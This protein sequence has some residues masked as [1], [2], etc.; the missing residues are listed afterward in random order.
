MARPP[1][2]DRGAHEAEEGKGGET[3]DVAAGAQLDIKTAQ[4]RGSGLKRHGSLLYVRFAFPPPV[5]KRVGGTERGWRTGYRKPASPKAPPPGPPIDRRLAQAL[6]TKKAAR[7]LC[8]CSFRVAKP[9]RAMGRG[10]DILERVGNSVKSFSERPGVR[11]WR[12]DSVSWPRD[13]RKSGRRASKGRTVPKNIKLSPLGA[14]R[15]KAF[16]DYFRCPSCNSPLTIKPKDRDCNELV[17]SGCEKCR[18][19][20][21][22]RRR[23]C[24]RC[25]A[26]MVIRSSRP[27]GESNKELPDRRFP[28]M[29]VSTRIDD[30]YCLCQ[31]CGHTAPRLREKSVVQQHPL[32]RLEAEIGRR[33]AELDTL[34]ERYREQSVVF[35]KKRKRT[36]GAGL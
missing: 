15:L 27:L 21:K 26:P 31:N 20:A 32:V 7:R 11:K 8:A 13:R 30:I 17:T 16:S 4:G 3:I 19:A 24:P 22:Q 1:R 28:A 9:G 2:D 10:A 6:R 12:L 36:R 23:M 29:C 25:Q 18:R 35:E 5:A 34:R 14:A 33:Q